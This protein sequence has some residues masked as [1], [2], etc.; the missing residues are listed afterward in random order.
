MRSG[1]RPGMISWYLWSQNTQTGFMGRT[2]HHALFRNRVR[3]AGADR[4]QAVCGF[5]AD[6]WSGGSRNLPK[7]DPSKICPVCLEASRLTIGEYE[8]WKVMRT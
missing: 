6:D 5:V 7:V 8:V 3:P 4:R 1:V 2:F